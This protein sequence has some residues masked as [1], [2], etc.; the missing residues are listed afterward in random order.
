MVVVGGGVSQEIYHSGLAGIAEGF[1]LDTYELEEVARDLHEVPRGSRDRQWIAQRRA[2]Q[3]LLKVQLRLRRNT[4]KMCR[5]DFGATLEA[6]SQAYGEV[7]EEVQLGDMAREAMGEVSDSSSSEDDA[8][9]R[10]RTAAGFEPR[11]G[12]TAGERYRRFFAEVGGAHGG[13]GAAGRD[14]A[15][16]DRLA[17]HGGMVF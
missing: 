5:K 16:A 2:N 17:D 13:G 12:E 4:E 10:R 14:I 7:W 9:P 6:L 8:P 15:P 11:H 1:L 3:K